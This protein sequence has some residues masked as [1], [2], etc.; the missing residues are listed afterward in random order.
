MTIEQIREI[1]FNKLKIADLK[2]YIE[3]NAPQ[4]KA[5]FVANAYR[6]TDKGKKAYSHIRAKRWFCARYCPD[7]LPKKK[8]I[9]ASD[10]AFSDWFGMV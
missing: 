7:I 1:G 10:D 6:T 2:A 3:A 8:K 9:S 5:E 4:D